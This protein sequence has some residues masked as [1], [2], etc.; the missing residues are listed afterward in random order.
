MA[1]LSILVPCLNEEKAVQGCIDQIRRVARSITESNRP[2]LSR[3][4]VVFINNGSTDRTR[5]IIERNVP[6]FP[7][8]TLI[9][10]PEAGY[11]SAYLAGLKASTGTH[12]FMADCDGTYDFSDIPKFLSMLHGGADL[13]LGNRFN[14]TL[15]KE[16]MPWLH[17]RIGNP[18]LSFLVRKFFNVGIGDVHCGARAI[19]RE[20][21]NRITLR[22]TGMEF[23]SEMVIACARQN[24]RISEIPIT[25]G[26]RIGISKLSSFRDGWRHLRLI[27]SHARS[28]LS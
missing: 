12:I 11:G 7:E 23:A 28:S 25:Y 2:T 10:E 20:A 17:R 8:L 5:S 6:L 19:S 27:L 18:A 13:V 16:N 21:L 3:I 22:A 24:M 14:E 26:G 4:E 9:D 15:E 1:E